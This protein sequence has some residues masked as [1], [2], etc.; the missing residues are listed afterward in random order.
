MNFNKQG[1]L[2]LDDSLNN[3][4]NYGA[5][6]TSG[7]NDKANTMSI[8]WA[9]IGNMWKKKIFII[10]ISNIRYTKEFIDRENTFT[11]SIPFD[12]K[13][14]EAIDICGHVSGRCVN[15]NERAGIKYDSGRIV[16]SPVVKGCQAYYECRVIL[17][18]SLDANEVNPDLNLDEEEKDYTLYFGEIIAEYCK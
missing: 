18:E 14:N 11:I 7:N 13:M 17:K 1:S 5:F 10:V 3:I 16:K 9:S 6:L 4:K 12:E 8:S 2:N 15:K